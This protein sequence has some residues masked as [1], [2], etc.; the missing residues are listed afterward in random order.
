MPLTAWNAYFAQPSAA[1]KCVQDQLN[2]YE[3]QDRPAVYKKIEKAVYRVL[4][5]LEL[6]DGEPSV[7]D[8]IVPLS[9]DLADD[10]WGNVRPLY[11]FF[12][13]SEPKP[14]QVASAELISRIYSPTNPAAVGVYLEYHYRTRYQSVEL[15]LLPRP[16]VHH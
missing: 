6:G 12:P 2:E 4:D 8:C 3:G 5:H 13:R 16:A 1:D 9:A 15:C 11:R 10:G 14:P 7:H